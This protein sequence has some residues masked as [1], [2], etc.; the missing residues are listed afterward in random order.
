[1]SGYLR[2]VNLLGAGTFALFLVLW[3]LVVRL[4]LL[5]TEYLPAPT[6]V[7]VGLREIVV[8]GELR[9]AL[10]HTLTAALAGW[11]LAAIVGVCAGMILGLLRPVWK[12]SMASVEA[13][14]ALPIVAF[15]PVAVLLLGFSMRMEIAVSFVAALWPIVLNTFAGMRAVETRTVE[16]GYVLRLRRLAQIWK[17]RLPAATSYIVVGLRLGLTLSL[18]LT[19]VSEM[20]GN[21]AGL[22]FALIQ[23]GQALQPEQMF[24]YVLVIGICGI[25]LN[26]CL[27]SLARLVFRGQMLAAGD[28]A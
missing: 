11:L 25:L 4:D 18:I 19:L 5:G 2:R 27:V 24:A 23:T 1:V 16:V 20:V 8:S 17:L 9:T 14:R 10:T 12:Y 21:P 13:L 28:T 3:E 7:A 26:A 6:G 22:G 15:V